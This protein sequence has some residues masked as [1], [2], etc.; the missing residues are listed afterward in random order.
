VKHKTDV[1][2]DSYAK[3]NADPDAPYLLVLLEGVDGEGRWLVE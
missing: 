1:H 2:L 3:L